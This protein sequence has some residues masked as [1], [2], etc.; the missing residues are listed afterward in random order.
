MPGP[1][2]AQVARNQN[3]FWSAVKGDPR[4][5]QFVWDL[6]V[7]FWSVKH[8]WASLGTGC[9]E[10]ECIL[11]SSERRSA[12]CTVCLG[13]HCAVLVGEACLGLFG[14]RLLG[15]RMHFGQ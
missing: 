11:V 10:P 13:S 12:Q 14:H 6:I 9:S 5:A 2:W 7:R 4:S 1:L 8:A 3:A 15:T